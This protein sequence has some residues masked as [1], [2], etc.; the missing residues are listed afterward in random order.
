[1]FLIGTK[2]HV[3][4]DCNGTFVLP[5]FT[6]YLMEEFSSGSD[7]SSSDESDE[8]SAVSLSSPDNS[9]RKNDKELKDNV[10][11]KSSDEHHTKRETS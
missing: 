3:N 2:G 5:A 4:G 10:C 7:E 1:M 8:E 9:N 11:G 6:Q